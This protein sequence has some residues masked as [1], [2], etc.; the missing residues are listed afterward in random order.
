[1]RNV[2]FRFGKNPKIQNV[3]SQNNRLGWKINLTNSA[4]FFH[5]RPFSLDLHAGYSASLRLTPSYSGVNFVVL[6]TL[7]RP[8][9]ALRH[10]SSHERLSVNPRAFGM[11][12]ASSRY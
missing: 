5:T 7:K 2:S 8:K 1:M 11:L 4:I 10:L 3:Q 12:Y 6:S 9:S